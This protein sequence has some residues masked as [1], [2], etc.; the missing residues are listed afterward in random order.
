MSCCPGGAIC[1]PSSIVELCFRKDAIDKR[2]GVLPTSAVSIRI[3]I[4]DDN[5]GDCSSSNELVKSTIKKSSS[6]PVETT[7]VAVCSAATSDDSVDRVDS[8]WNW[9]DAMTTGGSNVGV[10]PTSPTAQVPSDCRRKD[11]SCG[12]WFRLQQS[13]G[14]NNNGR[15]AVAGASDV[16]VRL[17]KLAASMPSSVDCNGSGGTLAAEA[18]TDSRLSVDACTA[19][20]SVS[21]IPVAAAARR[22]G[23]V[24]AHEMTTDDA[25]STETIYMSASKVTDSA[26]LTEATA[27]DGTRQV[28]SMT[29]RFNSHSSCAGSSQ[30]QRRVR[31]RQQQS[32]E[33]RQEKKA[34]TMLSAVLLVFLVTWTPYNVFTVIETLIPN[35]INSTLYAVGLYMYIRSV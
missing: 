31:Q 29:R 23:S 2:S 5:D 16:S 3:H 13:S 25:S 22:A 33:K 12:Y 10:A 24:T 32:H 26:T 6:A 19:R 17:E 18:L 34:V 8:S 28:S 7:A 1:W 9:H 30:Q 27:E 15:C 35:S 14:Y 20:Y 11:A 21:E 4:N